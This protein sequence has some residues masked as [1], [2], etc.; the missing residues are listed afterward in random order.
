MMMMMIVMARVNVD[1]CF[2]STS[3]VLSIIPDETR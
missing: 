2:G 1:F 3:G